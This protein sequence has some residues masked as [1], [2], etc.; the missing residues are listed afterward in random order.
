MNNHEIHNDWHAPVYM[1]IWILV[2]DA[3]NVEILG[4]AVGRRFRGRG[5]EVLE[6]GGG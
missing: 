6:V 1:G 5:G 3:L 2:I 4:K